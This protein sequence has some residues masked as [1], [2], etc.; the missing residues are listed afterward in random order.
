MQRLNFLI[1]IRIIDNKIKC[2]KVSDCTTRNLLKDWLT[3]TATSL[4]NTF[5]SKGHRSRV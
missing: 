2:H 5:K 4:H 1:K 3:I